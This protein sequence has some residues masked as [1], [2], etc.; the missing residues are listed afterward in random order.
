MS[1][2]TVSI[3]SPFTVFHLTFVV[4]NIVSLV[5]IEISDAEVL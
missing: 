3:E 2:V 5:V 1:K 4:S